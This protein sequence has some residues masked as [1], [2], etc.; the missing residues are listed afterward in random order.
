MNQLTGFQRDLLWT[1]ADIQ[2][3]IGQ[4]IKRELEEEGY[5]VVTHGRFYP[6][7]DELV[8][9]GL[10]E[11]HV[12]VPDLRTN[13]YTLTDEGHRVLEERKRWEADRANPPAQVTAD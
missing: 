2:P 4:E 1:V 13:T 3:A 12:Q 11:K 7:M 6:N 9:A 5:E 8:S 10:V